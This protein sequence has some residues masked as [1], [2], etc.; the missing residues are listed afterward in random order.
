MDATGTYEKGRERSLGA[1]RPVVLWLLLAMMAYLS[2][3]GF[4]GGIPLLRDP[5]GELAG[6]KLSWLKKTPVDDFVL[7]G[8]FLIA[9]FGV[10]VLVLMA[11]LIWRPSPGWLRRLDVA[12]GR[13]WAWWGTMAV[14]SVLVIWILYEFLVLPA[15]SWLMPTLLVLGFLMIGLPLLPSMRSY[16]K[17]ERPERG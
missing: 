7:P 13:H 4:A 1:R 16:Y 15:I 3:G 11:G 10:A 12:T 8:I 2:V 14:G 17:T 9:V 6:A 5:T